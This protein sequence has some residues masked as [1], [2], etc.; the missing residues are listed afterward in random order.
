[1]SI[2][3]NSVVLLTQVRL[4]CLLVVGLLIMGMTASSQVNYVKNAGQWDDKIL[5][6]AELGGGY[7]FVEQDRLTYVLSEADK[8]HL[9]ED[10]SDLTMED[11]RVFGS[12][13]YQVEF[14]GSAQRVTASGGRKATFHHNYFNSNDRQKW[15]SNVPIYGE[16][17]LQEIYPNIDVKL[18]GRDNLMEYDFVVHPGADVGQISMY[19]HGIEDL[20]IS[21]G[22]LYLNTPLG[23]VVELAPVVYQETE[24]GRRSVEAGFVIRED[25]QVG[26]DILE[27]YD[28]Q[29]ELIIDP[30]L[31]F[32]TYTG[33]L[34]DNWGFSATYDAEGNLYSGGM[35]SGFGY[36]DT[37]GSYDTIF[38]GGVSSVQTDIGITKYTADG[39]SII[40]STYLGGTH[41][42][43]PHSLIVNSK[44]EL[45]VYGT[46][47]SADYPVTANAYDISFNGG[48]Q[49]FPPSSINYLNGS[50]II[51]TKFNADGSNL[52]GSTFFGGNSNDGLNITGFGSLE[53]NYGDFAR[54]DLALSDNDDIFVSSCT[55]GS[56]PGVGGNSYQV[57]KDA[58]LT[59]LIARFSDDLSNLEWATYLGGSGD[60]A[61]FSIEPS[62]SDL[63]IGGGTSS[64]DMPGMTGYNSVY[65]G[66]QAD[67]FL[68]KLS[69]DGTTS[70]GGTFLGTDEYDQVYFVEVDRNSNI[71]AYGQSLGDYDVSPGTYNVNNAAQFIHKF[72]NSLV[73]SDFSTVFGSPYVSINSKQVNISPTAFLVDN[74]YNIYAIGWG[75]NVN[76]SYNSQTGTTMNMETT[77]DAFT[78][79]TDGSDF[80]LIV[81]ED[82]A[83][84]VLYA[85]Y[86][87]EFGGRGD[88]VDGG[89]SRFDKNGFVYHA[90]CASCGGTD[91]FPTSA[92]A[93][94]EDNGSSNCNMASF[95]IQFDFAPIEAQS[96]AD[97]IS[98]CPPLE[99]QF[100]NFSNFDGEEYYWDFD[101]GTVSEEENPFHIFTEVGVY[102][103]EFVIV[104]SSNCI[105][106]DT[107]YIQVIVSDSLNT[108]I[109]D[110]DFSD[111]IC[112]RTNILFAN[113]SENA[114]SYLWDFGDGSTSDEFSPLHTYS[115][116]GT[117]LVS[118]I[119]DP[120]SLCSDSV[121]HEVSVLITEIQADF[122]F[123]QPD[124]S[125]TTATLQFTE[126]SVSD[127]EIIQWDWDFGDSSTS[128]EQH[129]LHQFPATGTYDVVLMVTDAT[130]CSDFIY[131][132]V[133]VS[134]SVFEADFSVVE[135]CDPFL[136]GTS[137]FDASGGE[138]LPVDWQ[139][140]FGDSSTSTAQDPIHIY[141]AE[142]IYNVTLV[143]TNDLGCVDSIVSAVE[144]VEIELN[145]QFTADSIGCNDPLIYFTNTTTTEDSI[146]QW[147]W[148][149]GDGDSSQLESPVHQYEQGGFY[150]VTLVAITSTGCQSQSNIDIN[151]PFLVVD[152]SI[153]A[154][155]GCSNLNVPITFNIFGTTSSGVGAATWDFGD[156]TVE[157]G[158]S[159]L[160][161]YT[162]PG[163]YD[164]LYV[165]TNTQGCIDSSEHTITI[166][167]SL[168]ADA[169]YQ[170]DVCSFNELTV[171]FD[172][173]LIPVSTI[174][175]II[176]DFGDG[177]S[178]QGET[179]PSHQY[180]DPGSYTVQVFVETVDGCTAS[181]VIQVEVVVESVSVDFTF[182]PPA[183]N[184]F[185]VSF[186]NESV[187]ADSIVSWHWDFGDGDTS[188]LEDPDHNYAAA[189]E[190]EV[191]LMAETEAGCLYQYTDMVSVIEVSMQLL[192]S[193][194]ICIG[195]SVL[196]P[197][198]S[199]FGENIIWD[200]PATL[201]DPNILQ[202]TATPE[203]TTIY[204]VTVEEVFVSGD[205]C[206]QSES[207]LVE[208]FP[209]PLVDATA[210]QYLIPEG[211]TVILSAT[212]GYVDY[213]WTPPGNL[214][215]P[216]VPEPEA[217]VLEDIT[218][219]VTVTD[220]HGCVNTDT[221]NLIVQDIDE[222]DLE[223]LFIPGAFSPNNDGLNDEFKIQILGGYDKLDL[224]IHDRWGELVFETDDISVGWDGRHDGQL[225]SS[226]AFG[227]FLTIYC[228]DEV[229]QEKGNIT[230]VR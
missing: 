126:L 123:G 93:W 170:F 162:T 137:F 163:V 69:Q 84:S 13:S 182:Q 200:P 64:P 102:D 106:S 156:G 172:V 180:N 35:V 74:C 158:F 114:N 141:A 76:R 66:G 228:N 49:A 184:T 8:L 186:L 129:P 203:Q 63:V 18:H 39:T 58:G 92:G 5:Y 34:S 52:L 19:Y 161:I 60:D 51:I 119:A 210:E 81:L 144:V 94:S 109:A 70:A 27:L 207:V 3:R 11:D 40:Y 88:H 32:S 185:L 133:D 142:G 91:D 149:F 229:R 212:S 187:S 122:V 14:V 120:G 165:I 97:P 121:M 194:A 1:M 147:I 127:L 209:L 190:Y 83:E 67:G 202:P 125:D 178:I 38:N 195:E 45:I 80:Y 112:L 61:A 191:I 155:P 218:Y 164:V 26:F 41:N 42:E 179:Q 193:L 16:V 124:C 152:F 25:G 173:D 197:L 227:Y 59:G 230:L 196:L 177:D 104:D 2:F 107:A 214:D 23:H 89:T 73:N 130:G 20:S 217:T 87:G 100:S 55:F 189:G 183:C 223:S 90:S 108:V 153:D 174:Q 211:E 176:W 15:R 47:G 105:I 138:T 50:D 205:T 113:E 206:R 65:G 221:V 143:V 7:V 75:G 44:N 216:T 213:D 10:E 135:N 132:Q 33:S 118:L 146:V 139:W 131:Q 86:F 62:G 226:D 56:V 215:D 43:I 77:P 72:D 192:D 36:P 117:Y 85:T 168:I 48:P 166:L 167:D 148:L 169:A 46:T 28:S 154:P 101:D 82:D 53:Y 136:F 225:L 151:V 220:E 96:H 29:R 6:R 145:V 22:Q 160:H 199:T 150:S 224:R 12:F 159:T 171:D 79:T 219:E 95:K 111:S 57:F 17:L 157:P 31:V 30:V 128:N 99:V 181:D 21:D 134:Q 71:Y 198:T 54:G 110:F 140:D 68:F 78:D 103:V 204:T 9:L 116:T 188:A 201:N 175:T 98:G 208:V 4:H 24:L 222:C 37:I 115:D